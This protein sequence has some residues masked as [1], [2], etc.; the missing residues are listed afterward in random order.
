[1][2]PKSKPQKWKMGEKCHEN[3]LLPLLCSLCFQPSIKS[4]TLNFSRWGD[5]G[6]VHAKPP[7]KQELVCP[8]MFSE[9][10]VEL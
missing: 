1:M 5:S 8:G 2:R 7:V 9:H 4:L 3:E 10:V 6:L